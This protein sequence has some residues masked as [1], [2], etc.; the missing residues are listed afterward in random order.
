M[1]HAHEADARDADVDHD[2]DA[3]GELSV[4]SCQLS[5]LGEGR[6]ISDFRFEISDLVIRFSF[7]S[8]VSE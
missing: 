8:K 5:L 4:V 6:S 1:D 3:P 7:R 2:S